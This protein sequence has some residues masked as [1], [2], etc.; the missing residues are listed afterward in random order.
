MANFKPELP[1]LNPEIYLNFH[2]F[3][4]HRASGKIAT[5][6][7]NKL[8]GLTL[9]VSYLRLSGKGKRPRKNGILGGFKASTS[10][11]WPGAEIDDCSDYSH[12]KGAG[13]N[14]QR[15]R[16]RDIKFLVDAEEQ[17]EANARH[18]SHRG[19]DQE[20]FP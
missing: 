15:S 8:A 11:L 4:E 20:R 19:A 7:I 3:A 5:L 1:Y 6:V 10:G 16:R 12:Q 18:R 13:A 9:F 17:V 14:L 2:V